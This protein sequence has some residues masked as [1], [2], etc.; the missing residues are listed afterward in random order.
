MPVYDFELTLAHPTHTYDTP[1]PICR[2]H[3]VAEAMELTE[4]YQTVPVLS[5]EELSARRKRYRCARVCLRLF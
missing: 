4:L 5:P 1:M 3:Q 2:V